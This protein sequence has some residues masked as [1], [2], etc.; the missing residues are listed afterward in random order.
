[1]SLPDGLSPAPTTP[2][3]EGV[4][5]GWEDICGMAFAKAYGDPD[6]EYAALRRDV[7]AI[8]YSV[9]YKWFVEGPDAFDTVNAVFSR[10]VA[11]IQPGRAAYGVVVDDDGMMIEDVTV[12]ELAEDQLLVVGGNPLTGDQLVR[13]APEGTTVTD[14]RDDY[15]ALSLQ[16]PKSRELLRRLTDVDVSNESLPY[17]SFAHGV[18]VAGLPATIIRLGFTAELGYEI[19]VAASDANALWDAVL[20]Q[21]DL[22][23]IPLGLDAL[24]VARTEAGMVMA[25]FEYDRQTTPFECGLAWALDFDK[26]FQGREGLEAKRDEVRHRLVS[27]VIEAPVEPMADRPLALDARR[28]FGDGRDIGFVTMAV[29]SPTLEGATLGL[30]RVDKDFADVGTVLQVETESGM[31]DA[32]V[33]RTPVYDPDRTKAKS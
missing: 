2:R 15:A 4:V 11:K 6:R 30:A 7:V 13:R 5:R 16:G 28:V 33:H 9:L 19:L 29:T 20:E 26:D 25:E 32:V 21:T 17:Y 27:L 24:L 12:L 23:V 14:R 3:F 22:G 10:D 31:V 8:E 18:A 1:M